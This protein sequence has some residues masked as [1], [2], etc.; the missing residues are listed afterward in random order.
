MTEAGNRA[1]KALAEFTQAMDDM[2][3]EA[4]GVSF[5]PQIRSLLIGQLE[6]QVAALELAAQQG[7]VPLE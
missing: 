6:N 2:M 5:P 4:A 3:K 7:G 1:R